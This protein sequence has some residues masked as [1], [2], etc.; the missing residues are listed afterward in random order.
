M[1][2][3]VN[4]AMKEMETPDSEAIL[5]RVRIQANRNQLGASD[6]SML[7]SRQPSK[8]DIG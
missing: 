7:P 4:P 2:H 5:D 3:G 8:K 1:T 6:H